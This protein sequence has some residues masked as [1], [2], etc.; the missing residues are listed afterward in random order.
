M[1]RVATPEDMFDSDP[2]MRNVYVGQWTYCAWEFVHPAGYE[3][4]QEETAEFE[5]LMDELE[6]EAHAAG[7]LV[8]IEQCRHAHHAVRK[9]PE[10]ALGTT[11]EVVLPGGF[12]CRVDRRRR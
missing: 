10:R 3:L 2:L 12:F 1:E 5:K 9:Q 6:I 11:T 4:D 8:T 7:I